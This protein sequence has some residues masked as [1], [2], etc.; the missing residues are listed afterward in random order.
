MQGIQEPEQEQINQ[1]QDGENIRNLIY[2]T[3]NSETALNNSFSNIAELTGA[4]NH[5]PKM[6][7]Q[8][9]KPGNHSF[10]Y[11]DELD[12]VGGAQEPDSTGVKVNEDDEEEM[13]DI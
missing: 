5:G 1:E 4:K 2:V 8:D 7:R 3:Q 6:N 12:V 10:M 13:K 9:S 11:G